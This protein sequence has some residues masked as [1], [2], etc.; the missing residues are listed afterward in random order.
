MKCSLIYNRKQIKMSANF[1]II[2]VCLYTFIKQFTLRNRMTN[3]QLCFVYQCIL[4]NNGIKH[5]WELIELSAIFHPVD[6]VHQ[7]LTRF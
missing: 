1:V 6:Y 2:V 4:T 7:N 5:K 3:N